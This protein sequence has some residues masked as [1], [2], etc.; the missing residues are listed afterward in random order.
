VLAELVAAHRRHRHALVSRDLLG[1]GRAR[2][3]RVGESAGLD[4]VELRDGPKPVAVDL[5]P[6]GPGIAAKR[7]VLF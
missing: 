1:L 2:L 5:D 3:E 4:E 6:V 7:P